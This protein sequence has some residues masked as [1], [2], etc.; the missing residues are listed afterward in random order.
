VHVRNHNG[1]L[2][3]EQGV[4]PRVLACFL[5]RTGYRVDA[6]ERILFLR[7]HVRYLVAEMGIPSDPMAQ[8]PATTVMVRPRE[9]SFE[10]VLRNAE[11]E[12]PPPDYRICDIA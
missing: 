4:E 1:Y 5:T 3:F 12:T 8:L 6:K 9:M 7:L 2:I 10:T 11:A